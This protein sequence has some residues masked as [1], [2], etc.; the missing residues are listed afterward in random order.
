LNKFIANSRGGQFGAPPATNE[1]KSLKIN[2][3]KTQVRIPPYPY[4]PSREHF[5]KPAQEPA[6]FIDCVSLDGWSVDFLNATV[7]GG[8]R[9]K[10]LGGCASQDT[11]AAKSVVG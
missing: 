10:Y 3:E 11:R 1:L 5:C 8:I 6:G 7:S 2:P 4:Y 9:G